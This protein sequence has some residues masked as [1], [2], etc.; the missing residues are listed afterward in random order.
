MDDVI[1][2]SKKHNTLSET[3]TTTIED[4]VSKIENEVAKLKYYRHEMPADI[5]INNELK[6]SEKILKTVPICVNTDK[7]EYPSIE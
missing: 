7:L 2:A 1:N 5:D 3:L 6:K 4:S